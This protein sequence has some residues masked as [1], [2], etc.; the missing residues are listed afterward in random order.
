MVKT[1]K[2]YIASYTDTVEYNQATSDELTVMVNTTSYLKDHRDFI[3]NSY[4][5]GMIYGH[6]DRPFQAF[7]K[8]LVDEMPQDVNFLEI[9]VYKGQ[10]LSLMELLATQ[11]G[12]NIQITGV[13]PL[14]DEPFA[15]YNRLPYIENLFNY[16][17]LSMDR[18][19]IIDGSSHEPNII[20]EVKTKAPYDIVYIDGDHSYEGAL[21]D[22][23]EFGPMLKVGGYMVVDD[24]ANYKKMPA[25]IW[26]G[27]IDVSNAVRDTLEKDPNYKEVFT[28]RHIRVFVK[29]SE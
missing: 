21:Q 12:K 8:M 20:A 5:N 22:I 18:T 17:D 13:T 1:L 10:I 16:F 27:I 11:T 26:A 15:A 25:G 29:V 9:G 7:W 4:N 28:I 3:E 19:K 24:A 2:D 14:Y 6:G 23:V